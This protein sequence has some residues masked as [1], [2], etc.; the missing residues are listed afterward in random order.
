MTNPLTAT[1]SKLACLLLF[2]IGST[3]AADL[4][5]DLAREQRLRTEI[6]DALLVGEAISLQTGELRFLAL[7]TLAETPKALGTVILVHDQGAHADWAQVIQPLRSG[8]AAHGWETLSLQMP[9]IAADAA[10]SS[11]RDLIPQTFPRLDFAME[12]LK[13][14]NMLNIVVLGHGLGAAMLTQWLARGPADEIQAFVAIG[15]SA[16]P[17]QDKDTLGALEQIRLPVLDIYG[18]RDLGPVLHSIKQRA[19]AAR[20]AENPDYRRVEIEGAD[21]GFHGQADLLLDRVR[22]WLART[23][24]GV[25]KTL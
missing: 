21:H 13:G 22:A 12:F 25:E 10:P 1:L 20:K 24:A 16:E 3:P 9:L 6:E 19:A 11:Y 23:A 7:H 8:L 5:S 4:T 18:S 2:Y 15:M 17:K 14:R